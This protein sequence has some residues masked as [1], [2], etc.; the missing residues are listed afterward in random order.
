MQADAKA[1]V[2]VL[3]LALALACG[4][5]SDTDWRSQSDPDL[6]NVRDAGV[7]RGGASGAGGGTGSSGGAAARGGESG[8][9]GTLGIGASSGSGSDSGGGPVIDGGPQDAGGQTGSAGDSGGGSGAAGS[10]GDDDAGG[11][12]LTFQVTTVSYKGNFSPKHIGAIWVMTPDNQF[13]KTLELWGR[14][15]LL[16]LVNWYP[17]SGGNYVD[18]V[19][20]ATL[21]SHRAHESSWNCRDVKGNAVPEGQYRMFMEFTED[22][23]ALDAGQQPKLY[24]FGFSTAQRPA[25]IVLPDQPYFTD[26]VL[27]IY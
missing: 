16:N 23:S 8:F 25:T 13:V 7:Q 19:T 15:R 20:S 2:L 22:N 21:A 10:G 12:A 14:V 6:G 17:Q 26:M 4:S 1:P 18:A 11:C 9:G 27:T 5:V 24:S 3:S